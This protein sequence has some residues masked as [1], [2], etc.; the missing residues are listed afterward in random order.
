MKA[1]YQ[2]MPPTTEMAAIGFG[3]FDLVDNAQKAI[4]LL[5]NHGDEMVDV[6]RTGFKLWVAISSRDLM[7][8]MAELNKA[9]VDVQMLI[10]AIKAEFGI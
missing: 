8:I 4:D 3:F 6:L 7:G 2:S 10:A 5:Q 1:M 9:V